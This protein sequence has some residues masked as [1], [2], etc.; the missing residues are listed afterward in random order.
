MKKR[1]LEYYVKKV[2]SVISYMKDFANAN[3]MNIDIDDIYN[4][5]RI[6]H[7]DEYKA[8]LAKVFENNR[9]LDRDDCEENSIDYFRY[10]LC[11]NN[12]IIGYG[13]Y[14]FYIMENAKVFLDSQI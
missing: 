8:I 2:N 1:Y 13:I 7:S 10:G 11:K 12:V 6:Y 3:E 4:S 14:I 9:N 5:D